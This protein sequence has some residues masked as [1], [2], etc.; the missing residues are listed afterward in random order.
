MAHPRTLWVRGDATGWASVV[1]DRPT[2]SPSMAGSWHGRDV[3]LLNPGALYPYMK[4]Q[5][6]PVTPPPYP[7]PSPCNHGR[8]EREQKWGEEG[9]QSALH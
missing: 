9:G 4:R 5:G 2:T 1:S 3:S 7:R 6:S 8:I